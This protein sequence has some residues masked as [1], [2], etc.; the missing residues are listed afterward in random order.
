M[1][2]L[3]LLFF[4]TGLFLTLC[5][6]P[7]FAQAEDSTYY[8]REQ[9]ENQ[10]REQMMEQYQQSQ[11]AQEAINAAQKELDSLTNVAYTAD[12]THKI[13]Q[14]K[15][16]VY[17]GEISDDEYKK[18]LKDLEK[19]KKDRIKTLKKEIKNQQ[20]IV[21][22]F[23]KDYEKAKKQIDKTLEKQEKNVNKAAE[24]S[25]KLAAALKECE[26]MAANPSTR[27]ACADKAKKKYGLSDE[28][29]ALLDQH[30]AEEEEE[31][32]R[33]EQ[34]DI[35]NY[36]DDKEEEAAEELPIPGVDQEEGKAG[37]ATDQIGNEGNADG[38]TGIKGV[39]ADA[40]SG[41]TKVFAQIAC[42]VMMFL[43]DL[44]VIAYIISGFGMVMFAYAAV[45]NKINWK[46]FAS[47]AIGLFLLAMIGPFVSY[48]TG[49]TTV[50]ANLQYGN[51]LG[52]RYQG[53]EGSSYDVD[54][55]ELP[56]VT[57]TAKKKWGFGDLVGSIKS[58]INMARSAYNTYQTAKSAIN[59]VKN[60][61][62]IIKNSIANS[63]GG[64]D[65]ILGAIGNTAG[66]LNNIGFAVSTG[67]GNTLA[68]IGNTANNMQDTFTDNAGR[69]E[70]AQQRADGGSSNLV[71]QWLNSEQGGAGLTNT[72][73]DLNNIISK[74]ASVAGAATTVAHE[75]QNIGGGGTFGDILGGIM[76]AGQALVSG[77]DMS[78]QLQQ[79]KQLEQQRQ[80][81]MQQQQQQQQQA[82]SQ[83]LYN[84]L[85]DKPSSSTT[86]KSNSTSTSTSTTSTGNTSTGNT[87]TN[88]STGN[89]R[90]NT[91]QTNNTPMNNAPTNNTP[92][93]NTQTQV[94][95][96]PGDSTAV[97]FTG[98]TD[99]T[100]QNFQSMIGEPKGPVYFD[101]KGNRVYTT[102]NGRVTYN[103]DGSKYI[104]TNSGKKATINTDGSKVVED[105]NTG[106][107]VH[108]TADGKMWR[109]D[110]DGKPQELD[111]NSSLGKQIQKL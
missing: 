16:Q 70:N 31:R 10:L 50:E 36:I 73:S 37:D 19:Q 46:H 83:P 88:T 106:V 80:Q 25:E 56:E 20:K 26:S 3:S 85:F 13:D 71:S 103:Q 8:T 65:G 100:G 55:G 108:L 35:Q 38:S 60:N 30:L 1:K 111:P 14:L 99:T 52:G 77:A 109:I 12:E 47:I 89:T 78:Q 11:K 23:T 48:F 44:R 45:F 32:K 104:E 40:G 91:T 74:G 81:Q 62:D 29:Q 17:N 63:G 7:N 93:N 102:S 59:T 90:T 15:K 107:Q 97:Q 22:D 54:G 87:R 6:M 53:I 43:I 95:N 27:Q 68:G 28:E 92:A 61:V 4:L 82:A 42:K 33:K 79:E 41:D 69:T 67:V 21:D 2:R 18:A 76:G 5:V 58:G 86:Q 98:F 94:L 84:S 105:T 51:Y 39:C 57:V 110:A 64:L 101:E 66:A 34:E 72:V 96:I 75:G 9:L 49:D 24:K